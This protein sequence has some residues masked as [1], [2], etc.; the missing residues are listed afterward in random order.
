MFP[1]ILLALAQVAK[2]EGPS[3][4]VK[5]ELETCIEQAGVIDLAIK[6]CYVALA[7]SEDERLNANWKQLMKAVAG[8]DSELGAP[9]LK[10]QRAWIAYKE[11]AC[12]HFLHAGGTLDRLLGQICFAELITRRADELAELAQFY[13]ETYSPD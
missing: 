6:D 10:E 12:A 5:A 13:Q 11:A 2:A 9:L 4:E 7:N 1:I 3:P 8:K